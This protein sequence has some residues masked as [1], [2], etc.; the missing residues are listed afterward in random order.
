MVAKI[1]ML[2]VGILLLVRIGELSMVTVTH[3]CHFFF[4]ES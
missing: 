2:C 3:L 1:R 4:F